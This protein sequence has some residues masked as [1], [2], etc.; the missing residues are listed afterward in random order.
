MEAISKI[1]SSTLHVSNRCTVH[2]VV[3]SPV[4]K[5]F[6]WN[7]GEF[8]RCVYVVEVIYYTYWIYYL[9]LYVN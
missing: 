7:A 4:F 1:S 6:V 5:E 3:A 9:K 2:V 8:E